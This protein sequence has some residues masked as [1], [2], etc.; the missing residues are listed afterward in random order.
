M[1]TAEL[2]LSINQVSSSMTIVVFRVGTF[3]DYEKVCEHFRIKSTVTAK[4]FEK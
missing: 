2:V 1:E 4:D 3:A